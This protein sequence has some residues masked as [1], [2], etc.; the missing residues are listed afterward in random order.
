MHIQTSEK[1][2]DAIDTCPAP[3]AMEKLDGRCLPV[4]EPTSM[5]G[6]GG[7]L[8]TG[9]GGLC[10]CGNHCQDSFLLIHLPLHRE[11]NSKKR[12]EL[13]F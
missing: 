2:V 10:H 1:T 5:D 7:A 4:S 11:Q 3:L 6:G 13:P 8:T 12:I 9:V